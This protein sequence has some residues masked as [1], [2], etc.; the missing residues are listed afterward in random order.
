[1][2]PFGGYQQTVFLDKSSNI[3]A[4]KFM[5]KY[6]PIGINFLYRDLD[7]HKKRLEE[8]ARRGTRQKSKLAVE[9][10]H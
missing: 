4:Q 5:Q 1:M 7:R 9:Y 8:I 2:A 10:S 6:L 3:I